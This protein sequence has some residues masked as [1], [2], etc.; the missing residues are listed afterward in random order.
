M[1][2]ISLALVLA[3]IVAACS[4]P[5]RGVNAPAT[6]DPGQTVSQ[7][8]ASSPA[9]RLETPDLPRVSPPTISVPRVR[10]GVL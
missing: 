6:P 2:T 9:P 1:R 8:A 4:W 7:G 3:T 5:P 10:S